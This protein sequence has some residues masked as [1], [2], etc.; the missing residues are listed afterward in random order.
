[1]NL[2]TLLKE[3]GPVITDGAMGT[4]F[5][6]KTGLPIHECERSN[7]SRPETILEIHREY[8][9]AGA[10]F[11]RTNTFSANTKSLGQ[12]LDEVLEIVRAG[13]R[14]AREAAGNRAVVAAD[15][16]TI[17]PREDEETDLMPEYLAIADAFLSEGADVFLFETLTEL[18]PFDQIANYLK[19]KNPD[20]K[21]LISFT[22]SP[23]GITRMGVPL[24]RLLD[25]LKPHRELFDGIGL[26]CGCGPA[27][28][29]K[30]AR[31]ILSY[32]RE[33]L[34]IPVLVMPN[35]GYPAMEESRMVFD[36]SPEYFSHQAVRI[37]EL[38]VDMIGGCCGTTPTHIR[39]LSRLTLKW[40]EPPTPVT[41]SV[42]VEDRPEK[43]APQESR[44]AQKLRKGEFVM[45]A[46]LD[47]PYGSC[48]DKLLAACRVLRDGGVDIVTLSDSPMAR[49]KLD[50]VVCGAKLQRETGVDVLP[51]FCC[52]DRNINAL[53]AMLLGAQCENI[54]T[55]LAVT[56][57]HVPEL[58]RGYIKP[59]FNVT[60][61][62]LMEIIS[63]MN[64][65]V[66]ADSPFTIGG[67]FNPN[68]T[69]SKA[70]LNRLE[71]KLKAG[72]LFFLTQPIFD[73]SRIGIVEKARSMGAKMLLGIMPLVSYRN[74]VYMNNEVPGIQIP[75]NYINRFSPDMSREKGQ[76]TGIEIALEIAERLRPHAD[77]FYFI[78]PFNR[79]EI[80]AELMKQCRKM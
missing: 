37:A 56:G 57:D 73:E 61:A 28:I 12:P 76:E 44:F 10:R 54:H 6:Q 5:T 43:I 9:E 19:S 35:A 41:T 49:V 55:I 45:A 79:A 14:L 71:K 18:S 7:G 24:R 78:T 48:V 66:F 34:G 36:T 67:A 72:A 80:I 58:D 17:Y 29:L 8:V 23:E 50:P 59:V 52:R 68:V 25:A 60:S 74:A 70:E 77:G 1:M 65:D 75:E 4:Y 39:L 13:Y 31:E 21:T 26:N 2:D 53:R 30:F 16:T 42:A 64:Q 63:Q 15:M 20:C 32:S 27:H 47:P 46:E 11:L 38:G 62:K 33:Y 3:K 69:N 22:V 51:H 40:K